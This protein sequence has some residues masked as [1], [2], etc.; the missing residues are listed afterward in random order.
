MLVSLSLVRR[1]FIAPLFIAR[2]YIPRSSLFIIRLPLCYL[3]LYL[4]RSSLFYRSSL[5]YCL[6]F[7]AHFIR[8]SLFITFIAHFIRSSLCYQLFL[9]LFYSFIAHF[10][11]SSLFSMLGFIRSSLYR[12]SLLFNI[13]AHLSFAFRYYRS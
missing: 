4:Y 9:L 6:S 8:S 13:I 1:S 10:I 12:S 3:Y 11:R 7:I 5:L 2:H